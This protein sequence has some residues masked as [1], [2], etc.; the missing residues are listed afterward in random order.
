ML[1]SIMPY[2]YSYLWGGLLGGTIGALLGRLIRTN[3]L[4]WILAF[5][6]LGMISSVMFDYLEPSDTIKVYSEI[7]F[8]IPV[9]T[10]IGGLIG[11][12]IR[13]K[14]SSN[15]WHWIPAFSLLGAFG[16]SI[17]QIRGQILILIPIGL[18]L[19][20]VAWQVT[21]SKTRWVLAFSLFVAMLSSWILLSNL[22]LSS[23]ISHIVT[24]VLGG[25]VAMVASLKIDNNDTRWILNLTMVGAMLGSLSKWSDAWSPLTLFLGLIIGGVTVWLI[26][27]L[28]IHKVVVF[29]IL[30]VLALCWVVA[31]W[32]IVSFW[33]NLPPCC[34]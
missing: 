15:K 26:L 32:N 18:I 9:F 20:A 31:G 29:M 13:R 3:L 11:E 30:A 5:A 33:E 1:L 24:F 12:L 27:S 23:Y 25:F 4:R 6:M 10:I 7:K 2:T 34:I 28:K 21:N 19:G 16:A 17:S 8:F 22:A 14:D